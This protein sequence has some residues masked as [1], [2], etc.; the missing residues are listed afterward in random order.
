[1]LS[2]LTVLFLIEGCP[3]VLL[4]ICVFCFL[5]SRPER[6][7]YLSEEQRTL[8]CTRLNADSLG[9]DGTGIDWRAVR[10]AFSDWKTYVV[11]VMYSCSTSTVS[12]FRG[13]LVDKYNSE[14]GAG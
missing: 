14:F 6:S 4:A 1:M 3:S 12:L 10:R 11:A 13:S 2:D 9:E 8:A 5:P 7:R